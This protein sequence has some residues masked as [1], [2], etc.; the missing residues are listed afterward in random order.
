[1]R[2]GAELKVGIITLIAILL[3]AGYTFYIRGFR[4]APSYRICVT[5][6]DARGLQR[7][8]PVRMSGVRIGE[9]ASIAINP[10]TLK[11]DIFLAID[12]K[13]I[14]FE[15]YRF[16]IATTGLIQERFVEV[17]PAPA[18][19]YVEK[20]KEGAC[21]EGIIQPGFSDLVAVGA[22]V[23]DNL[24]RTSRALNVV[25]TDQ[26]I[27]DGLRNALQAFTQA[28]KAASQLATTTS[29]FAASSEDEIV[30]TLRV[31]G[32]SARDVQ[33][34]T[35]QLRG[36]LAQGTM[37][38]DLEQTLRHAREA[39]A[40]AD[41]AA[42]ALAQLTADPEVPR[43]LRETISA[44]HDAAQSAKKVGSDLEVFSGELREAA[45][46]IPRVARE[47][48]EIA[49]TAGSLRERLK[50]PQID[51]AFDVVY[52][53]KADRWFSSGRLDIET[54]PN[55]FLRLGLDDIGEQGNVNVQLA[56]RDN[57]RTVRYGLVR[58]R[59]GVGLDF[60]L[61]R[62]T[63]LSLDIFDPN[64]LRADITADIPV[65]PG[66]ADWSILLGA[67]DIGYEELFIA[68]ARLKK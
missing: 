58:S 36:R 34:M 13:H 52:S 21:V 15:D 5:F 59:L 4:A 62:R 64:D 41:R 50:P 29:R 22:E 51:A 57:G 48:G 49:G 60:N 45:P 37:L 63:T 8:D 67:R 9:V 35:S 24:N 26:E 65:V 17:I 46:V 10:E 7:G 14:L 27:L 54:Q 2:T 12:R 56:E 40:N 18:N 43:E 61:P 32:A 30:A 20:L 3:V 11:A 47:A 44:L 42:T 19:P 53:S 33:T 39:A 16:Q 55:R 66:R 31:L 38:D 68:G 6:T 1:M 28:A 23:L 25:L